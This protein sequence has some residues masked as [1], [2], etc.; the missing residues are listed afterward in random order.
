M[1]DNLDSFRARIHNWAR[2]YKDH[3]VRAESN[4]MILIRELDKL[5]GE[6]GESIAPQTDYLD[7]DFIDNCI[8][9][10]R[11]K[12]PVFENLFPVLKAEYLTCHSSETFENVYDEKKATKRRARYANVFPWR[13]NDSLK[14]AEE[15]LMEFVGLRE[16]SSRGE[17]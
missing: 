10:L 3:F 4:I 14:R 7:A 9:Q 2:V 17:I 15:M 12:N 13:Y 8:A 6:R 1:T 16:D 5:P 11:Q